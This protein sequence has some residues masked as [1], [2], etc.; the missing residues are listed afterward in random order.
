MVALGNPPAFSLLYPLN[1]GPPSFSLHPCALNPEMDVLIL[2]RILTA[3]EYEA[4]KPPLTYG[5][6]NA[7]NIAKMRASRAEQDVTEKLTEEGWKIKDKGKGKEPMAAD[8]REDGELGRVILSL[9]RCAGGMVW[10]KQIP[11]NALLGL[12]WS[13]DGEAR[14]TSDGPPVEWL[15]PK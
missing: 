8:K 2:H 7:E 4:S 9:W 10:E 11:G 1:P 15:I 12:V 5:Q 14:V 6:K 13:V 3:E